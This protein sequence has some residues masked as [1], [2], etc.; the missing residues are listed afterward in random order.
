M[1]KL[2]LFKRSL[3]LSRQ[4]RGKKSHS[5]L[6]TNCLPYIDVNESRNSPRVKC[7]VKAPTS[8]KRWYALARSLVQTIPSVYFCTYKVKA[9]AFQADFEAFDVVRKPTSTYFDVIARNLDHTLHIKR[10]ATKVFWL[11]PAKHSRSR[12][13][14]RVVPPRND[15]CFCVG[16][17]HNGLGSSSSYIHARPNC[18]AAR[19]RKTR[20]PGHCQPAAATQPVFER[21]TD[22]VHAKEP[23]R[24]QQ[25]R[26]LEIRS[27]V[28][29]L[30]GMTRLRCLL[31]LRNTSLM[32]SRNRSP[33]NTITII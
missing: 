30:K 17:I 6:G 15:R 2:P 23:K 3:K 10:I 28:S 21:N 4:C 31:G 27:G 32:N 16:A 24:L 5:P 14:C 19:T 18:Y 12:E 8:A 9:L 33:G 29:L 11:Q 1:V 25:S 13:D 22:P 7:M 20:R 26:L